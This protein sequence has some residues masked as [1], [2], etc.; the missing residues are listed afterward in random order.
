L[1]PS[2]QANLKAQP[3]GVTHDGNHVCIAVLPLFH[4]VGH[5]GKVA[6]SNSNSIGQ[7]MR[8]ANFSSSGVVVLFVKGWDVETVSV[9]VSK[10][11]P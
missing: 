4:K 8:V 11:S 5:R 9:E 6:F 7:V 3:E 10:L 1:G 2:W